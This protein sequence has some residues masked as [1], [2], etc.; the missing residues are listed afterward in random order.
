MGLEGAEEAQ[1]KVGPLQW[2]TSPK[3]FERSFLTLRSHTGPQTWS[4]EPGL[5][6]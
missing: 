3:A 5:W 1:P 2:P 4:E 6:A